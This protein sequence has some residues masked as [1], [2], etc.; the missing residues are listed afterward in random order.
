M[1]N[2]ILVNLTKRQKIVSIK[3]QNPY[4]LKLKSNMQK[5]FSITSINVYKY[6]LIQN[7]LEKRIQKMLSRLLN[8]INATYASSDSSTGDF[9]ICLDEEMRVEKIMSFEF[10][11]FMKKEAYKKYIDELIKLRKM[12][13]EKVYAN[14]QL[15]D[16]EE[17]RGMGR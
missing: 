1:S 2:S 16:E 11:K 9:M 4:E 5:R 14:E 8:I 15:L 6:E 12:L 13:E 10:K 17:N 3:M 7:H